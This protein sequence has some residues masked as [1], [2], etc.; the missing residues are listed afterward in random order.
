MQQIAI[1]SN[2]Y[3]S[4]CAVTFPCSNGQNIV[5]KSIVDCEIKLKI[6]K[7]KCEINRKG[8]LRLWLLFCDNKMKF[9]LIY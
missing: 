3:C 7:I 8:W 1:N 9:E 6:N 4:N 5:S 2:F